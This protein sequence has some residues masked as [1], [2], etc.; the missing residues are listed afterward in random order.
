MYITSTK[1]L[2]CPL[3]HVYSL[4]CDSKSEQEVNIIEHVVIGRRDDL[5]QVMLL[6]QCT[7]TTQKIAVP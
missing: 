1:L 7:V 6:K 4:Y 5:Q 2:G 3:F